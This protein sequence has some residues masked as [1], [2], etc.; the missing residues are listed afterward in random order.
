[1]VTKKI[2]VKDKEILDFAKNVI[3]TEAKQA[4][5]QIKN[6]DK[7]FIS[8]VKLLCDLEGKVVVLGIG[9]SG[10]IGRKIAATFSSLGIPSIFLHP[11]ELLHG[12]L[13]LIRQNDIVLI[14]SYSGE[15]EEIKKVLPFIKNF[16]IKII[17]FTGKKSSKLAKY[18]DIVINTKVLKEACPYN[19][20][21]TSSTTAML[22]VGDALGITVARLKGFK[23][24]DFAKY[25]PS[26]SLGKQLTLKVKDI[27]RTG[28]MVPKVFAGT[29]V[30]DALFAM[31]STKLGA[32][33]VID[34]NGRLIG[35]FTDGDLRR[36]F[37]KNSDILQEKISKVMTKNPKY[38]YPDELVVVAKEMM[39]K[40]NCDNLPVVD[41]NKRV[42]GIIDERDILQEGL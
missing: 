37:Q 40:F 5:F 29:K 39:E 22:V 34:K 32:T 1:M 3:K 25:H 35:Y 4:L 23:K 11:V 17:S 30:K 2:D 9:K 41:K 21:P 8:V 13:G 31:T 16:G 10:L 28:K 18:S 6:L 12:D 24:E 36:S 15:T 14:L 42:V 20:V 33:T 27:M 38:I 19:I 26:G 7:N